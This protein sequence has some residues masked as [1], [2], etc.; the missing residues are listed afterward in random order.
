MSENILIGKRRDNG[1]WELLADPSDTYDAHNRAYRKFST[2]LPVSDTHSRVIF[3]RIQNT[4][5]PLTLITSSENEKRNKALAAV[6]SRAENAGKDAEV[7]QQRLIKQESDS[8]LEKKRAILDEKNALVNKIREATGQEPLDKTAT[9]ILAEQQAAKLAELP[10]AP[11]EA[12]QAKQVEEKTKQAEAEANK[13]T[14]QILDEKN[15]LVEKIKAL[16]LAPSDKPVTK[17]K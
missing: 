16:N 10:P 9:E 17:T 1:K 6:T 7:R 3:G 4:N 12:E 2:N 11:T 15:A 14:K 13:S 8:E 5:T